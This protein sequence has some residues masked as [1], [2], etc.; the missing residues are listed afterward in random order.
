MRFTEK[1]SEK[2]L[3]GERLDTVEDIKDGKIKVKYNYGHPS[4]HFR[5]IFEVDFNTLTFRSNDERT[6]YPFQDTIYD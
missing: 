1:M 3:E 5:K 4:I 2:T 6:I